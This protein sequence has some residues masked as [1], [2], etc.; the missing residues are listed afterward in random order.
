MPEQSPIADDRR[1]FIRLAR[2]LDA[3]FRILDVHTLQTST[4][5]YACVIPN[6]SVGGCRIDLEGFPQETLGDVIRGKKKLALM[7][8]FGKDMGTFRTIATIRWIEM[9]ESG[10]TG[11][12]VAFGETTQEDDSRLRKFIVDFLN[13]GGSKSLRPPGYWKRT[14]LKNL[15]LYVLLAL[16]FVLAF[17]ASFIVAE[18]FFSFTN[19]LSKKVKHLESGL[20]KLETM[21]PEEAK[22][23]LNRL[24]KMDAAELR[25]AM[26]R[27]EGR[28]AE[29]EKTIQGEEK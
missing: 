26:D 14:L 22:D 23:A 27:L 6:I 10:A 9:M 20:N 7:I 15:R 29:L 11:L 2:Q 16:F 19:T 4:E 13:W 5:S 12:G 3:G 21:T 24:E 28:Q 17:F 25:R 18:E 1:R 8:E